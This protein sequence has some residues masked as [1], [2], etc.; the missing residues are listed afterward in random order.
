LTAVVDR[1]LENYIEAHGLDPVITTQ[2]RIW[3]A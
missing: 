3:S 1:Q 2:E